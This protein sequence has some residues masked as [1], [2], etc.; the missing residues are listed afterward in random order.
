MAFEAEQ[1]DRVTFIKRT[2]L[3][4]AMAVLA[5]V[6]IEFAIF[7]L[8]GDQLGAFVQTYFSGMTA[9]LMFGAFMVVAWVANSWALSGGSILKQY[10]GLALYVVFESIIFV[11]LLYVANIYAPGAISSAAIVTAATFG[12]LTVATLVTKTDFSFLRGI[13]VVASMGAFAFIIASF[14]FQIQG[15]GVIFSTLMI[16]LACG[17]ILYDTSNVMH[18]YRTDQHVAASLALFASV[19]LLFFYILRLF[20]ALRD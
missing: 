15:T 18:H 6:G 10:A 9:M 5:F 17:Y 3:H 2:Y 7:T 1:A 20:M 19:A 8:A 16:V 12:G 14:F 13:L 4:L 11:P